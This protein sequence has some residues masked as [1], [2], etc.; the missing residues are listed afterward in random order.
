MSDAVSSTTKKKIILDYDDDQIEYLINVIT[1]G[2]DTIQ[3]GHN[4]NPSKFAMD[5]LEELFKQLPEEIK[6]L[7]KLDEWTVGVREFLEKKTITPV[8]EKHDH[9]EIYG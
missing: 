4:V 1:T 7:Y 8:K 5:T 3:R 9:E 2:I 6:K